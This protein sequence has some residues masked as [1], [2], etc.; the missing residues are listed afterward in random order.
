[1]TTHCPANEPVNFGHGVAVA[2]RYSTRVFILYPPNTT[3]ELQV[4]SDQQAGDRSATW[5]PGPLVFSLILI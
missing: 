3:N 2:R 4:A 1:M 5:A